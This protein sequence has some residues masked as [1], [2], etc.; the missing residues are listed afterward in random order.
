MVF[1]SLSSVHPSEDTDLPRGNPVHGKVGDLKLLGVVDEKIADQACKEVP[2]RFRV[3]L[4][5][6]GAE[7]CGM[8]D[9]HRVFVEG[10]KR[11][12]FTGSRRC[13]RTG[14]SCTGK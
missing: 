2:F 11:V 8:L 9:Q 6:Q 3:D 12:R 7:E 5:T 14:P 10:V 1:R 13:I 4:D